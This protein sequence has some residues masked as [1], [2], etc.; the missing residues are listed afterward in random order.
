MVQCW[1]KKTVLNPLGCFLNFSLW[2]TSF[3]FFVTIAKTWLGYRFTHWSLCWI[4]K[5]KP[6]TQYSRV[7]QERCVQSIAALPPYFPDCNTEDIFSIFQLKKKGIDSVISVWMPKP[8]RHAETGVYF[9]GTILASVLCLMDHAREVSLL[10][11]INIR[12][13]FHTRRP[14]S[15][16]MDVLAPSQRG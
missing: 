5:T 6:Y 12:H 4:S 14:C 10:L 8:I 16:T 1:I 9:G 3:F 11:F 2:H 7:K 13:Q 15:L